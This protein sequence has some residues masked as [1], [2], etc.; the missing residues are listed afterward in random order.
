MRVSIRGCRRRASPESS[1]MVVPLHRNGSSSRRDCLRPACD[2]PAPEGSIPPQVTP[3]PRRVETCSNLR[4]EVSG[5][6]ALVQGASV[7]S[8]GEL[9][10]SLRERLGLS[11][12][13]SLRVLAST[14]RT[15]LLER[16]G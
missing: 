1:F 12:L 3:V 7:L 6:M 11:E 14:P 16:T 8:E 2:L 4:G 15:L 13:Q 5:S 10:A 9:S